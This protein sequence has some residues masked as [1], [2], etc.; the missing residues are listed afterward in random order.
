LGK[1]KTRGKK[2]GKTNPFATGPGLEQKEKR[3]ADD[4][5]SGL[6]RVEKSGS[7]KSPFLAAEWGGRDASIDG[8]L[9][10]GGR[11]ERKKKSSRSS[12]GS[13]RKGISVKE[14]VPEE[15]PTILIGLLPETRPRRVIIF[16]ID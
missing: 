16:S 1:K 12:R 11:S 4:Q 10:G 2:T 8:D 13:G 15:N 3:P 9:K 7:L 6:G 5:L 14:R